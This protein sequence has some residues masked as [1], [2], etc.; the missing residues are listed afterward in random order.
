MSDVP[1]L[2]TLSSVGIKLLATAVMVVVAKVE[3]PVAPK[4]PR[5]SSVYAV[6]VVPIPT[7]PYVP[8][9]EPPPTKKVGTSEL[10]P[11]AKELLV[12]FNNGLLLSTPRPNTTAPEAVIE[13]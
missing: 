10:K 8:T 3:V 4:V 1:K 9:P 11:T 2:N 12:V 5:T 6:L 13:V 7:W